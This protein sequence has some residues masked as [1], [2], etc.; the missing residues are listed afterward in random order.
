[1]TSRPK[2]ADEIEI[3]REGGRRLA[4]ILNMLASHVEPGVKPTDISARAAAEIKKAGMRPVVLGY[5]GFPDVMCVSVNEVIVHGVPQKKPFADGDVVKLDLTLG[6]K[7]L[8]VDSALTVIAG[9]SGTADAKRLVDTTKRALEA[10]IAAIHGNG[11]RVGDI[12]AAV[13]DVLEKNKLGVIR[14]LVG[15][16]IGENIHE[17]PNIPNYGVSGAGPVLTTGMTICIEPMAAL[18]DWHVT[19]DKNG[20]VSMKDGSIGAHFEH[21]VL[22]TEDGAEILTT[23]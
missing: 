12:S 14:E 4:T 2:S 11:T 6:Y 9:G 23:P 15:H 16:G 18:G 22:I 21:T 20:T 8:I 19:V 17:D 1:M 7:S 3:M 13:Q 5:E 10:G